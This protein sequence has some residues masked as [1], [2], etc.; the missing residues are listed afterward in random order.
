MTLP[1]SSSSKRDPQLGFTLIETL[2]SIALV[3]MTMGAVM[4]ALSQSSALQRQ[5]LDRLML[6]EFGYSKLQ[7]W[8]VGG[9]VATD[10]TGKVAGGWNWKLAEDIVNPNPPSTLDASMNYGHIVVT[11]WKDTQPEILVTLET[12]VARRIQ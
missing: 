6:T 10:P 4:V 11:V 8:A 2:I 9:R 3:A 5:R 12:T 1:F 7:E